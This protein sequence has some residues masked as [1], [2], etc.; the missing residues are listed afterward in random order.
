MHC[1]QFTIHARDIG[2][3]FKGFGGIPF[4]PHFKKIAIVILTLI[5]LNI[6]IFK[7]TEGQELARVHQK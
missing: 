4:K 7:P 6:T 1:L 2:R 3:G 5:I